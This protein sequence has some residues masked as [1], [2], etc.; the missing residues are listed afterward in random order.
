MPAFITSLESAEIL[1]HHLKGPTLQNLNLVRQDVLKSPPPLLTPLGLRSRP[2]HHPLLHNDDR[3]H[4]YLP[5]HQHSILRLHPSCIRL[6]GSL[7]G[8]Q[9]TSMVY[10]VWEVSCRDHWW[11]L[12]LM[13]EPQAQYASYIHQQSAV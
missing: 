3:L 5:H 4:N 11:L 9:P 8:A 1:P 12:S 6:G 7:N 13:V 2:I 10:E